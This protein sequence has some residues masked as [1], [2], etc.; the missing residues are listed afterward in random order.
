MIDPE[1]TFRQRVDVRF[2]IVGG[3]CV[4]LRQDADEVLGLNEVGSR[5]FALLAE[6][7]RIDVAIELLLGEFDVDRATLEVDV[8]AF[9]Q[10]LEAGGIIEVVAPVQP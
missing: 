7:R 10:E 8:A 1:T 6:G 2:R 3:E 9:L 5:L 4:I